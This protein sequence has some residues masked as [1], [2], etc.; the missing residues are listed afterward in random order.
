MNNEM[1]A[2]FGVGVV[3]VL[4]IG[5]YCIAITKNLIRVLI[6]ME[7]MTKGVTLLLIAAGRRAD[8]LALAQSLAITLIVIEVA[9][10]VVA[11]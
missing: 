2:L 6:G 1:F 9:V 5:V 10:I 4:A 8:R 11:V 3:C 7:V